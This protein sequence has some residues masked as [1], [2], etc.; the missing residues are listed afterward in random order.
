M[1]GRAGYVTRGSSAA[2]AKDT[3]TTYHSILQRI[4]TISG[5]LGG[6]EFCG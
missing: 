4:S 1:R 2:R 3:L 5:G 6:S